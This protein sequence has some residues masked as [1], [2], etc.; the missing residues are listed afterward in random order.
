MTEHHTDLD[1]QRLAD[2]TSAIDETMKR[3]HASLDRMEANDDRMRAADERLRA[4]I[5]TNQRYR[6]LWR[7]HWPLA[8]LT[9]ALAGATAALLVDLLLS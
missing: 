7:P 3:L 8:Y 5:E 6:R 9:G 1:Q 4:A 2:L